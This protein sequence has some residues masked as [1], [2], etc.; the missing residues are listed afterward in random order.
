[1][2]TWTAEAGEAKAEKNLSIDH[3]GRSSKP[4]G[5]MPKYVTGMPKQF[6]FF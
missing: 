3:K 2:F 4:Y 5:L 1:M 6:F